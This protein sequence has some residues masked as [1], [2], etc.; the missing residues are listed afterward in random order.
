[1]EK[2]G[3]SYHYLPVS[4]DKLNPAQVEELREILQKNQG[5]VFVHCGTGQR[6]CSLFL[7]A[8]GVGADWIQRA[9][10]L[11]FPVEDAK[12]RSFLESLRT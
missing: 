9:R 6:A 7:V 3:L 12:L 4:L 10:E 2:L 11:G 1:V 5:R 8:S